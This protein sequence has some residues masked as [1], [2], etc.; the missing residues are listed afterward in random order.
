MITNRCC[1]HGT[2]S[3]AAGTIMIGTGPTEMPFGADFTSNLQGIHLPLLMHPIPSIQLCFGMKRMRGPRLV[4][5]TVVLDTSGRLVQCRRYN[6]Q[7]CS[8]SRWR[9][10][11][12]SAEFSS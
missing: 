8:R 4:P 6:H 1:E 10:G 7:E 5:Y 12:G 2:C 9:S 3:G 11:R